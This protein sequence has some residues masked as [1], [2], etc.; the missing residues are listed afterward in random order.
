MEQNG[1]KIL[2]FRKGE[3]LNC[4]KNTNAFMFI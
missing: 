4:I 3:M 2:I 1:K